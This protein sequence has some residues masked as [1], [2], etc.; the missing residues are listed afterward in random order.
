MAEATI[1]QSAADTKASRWAPIKEMFAEMDRLQAQIKQDREEIN[2][3]A[4]HTQ[5]NLL[6][7]RA[8]LDRI[9]AS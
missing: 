9:A 2:R 6:E 4:A 1:H 5:T 7:I 8:A 3:L